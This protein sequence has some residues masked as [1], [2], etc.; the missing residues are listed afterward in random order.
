MPNPKQFLPSGKVV[1]EHTKASIRTIRGQEVILAADVGQIYGETT[2][3]I[4]E[5]AKRHPGKLPQDFMFQ[6]TKSEFDELRSQSATSKAGR[7]G[8]QYLPYAFT[9][10]GVLQIANLINTDLADS[11]SV[12]VIRAFVEMRRTIVA[13]Q[14]ALVSASETKSDIPKTALFHKEL[15]P[16]LQ[17]T[18]GRILDSVIDSE[19]GSTVKDEALDILKESISHL[20]EQLRQK[21]LQN[22]EITARVSKL[23]AEA[24]VQRATARKTRAESEQIEF[25][26]TIRKLRLVLDAQLIMVSDENARDAQQ[27][28]GLIEVLKDVAK[29]N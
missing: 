10:H 5:R 1:I 19:S 22:E 2:K 28:K 14:K 8:T 23:L 29:I 25:L 26:N 20:K 12:F 13:Q 21:G 11:V 24:E 7:G 16:K 15:L 6:L 18:I 4:N 27:L 9:E 3:R 17:T